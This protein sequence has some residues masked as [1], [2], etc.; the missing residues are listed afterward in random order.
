MSQILDQFFSPKSCFNGSL[1]KTK[2]LQA[3]LILRL[4]DLIKFFLDET[5]SLP[6]LNSFYLNAYKFL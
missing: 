3:I 2:S 5:Y 1:Y 6:F 4:K